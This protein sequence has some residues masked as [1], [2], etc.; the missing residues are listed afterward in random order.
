MEPEA[1][2]Q[3]KKYS[4]PK[5][6]RL[7]WI[8]AGVF[9]AIILIVDLLAIANFSPA[10]P[11]TEESAEQEQPIQ[12]VAA[13]A[14]T[15]STVVDLA[16]QA[17]DDRCRRIGT[18][19]VCYGNNTVEAQLVPG[20]GG[21]FETPGDT[22]GVNE[23]NTLLTAPLN[24]TA[25]EWG[26]AVFK[27]QADLPGTV[28]GQNVTILV[29]GNVSLDNTSGDMQAF[30]FTTGLGRVQCE[31]VPFDGIVVDMPD[32]AGISLQ[33]NDA[34]VSLQGT[35]MLEAEEGESMSINLIKGFGS[36]AAFGR[37]QIVEA[38]QSVSMPLGSGGDGSR[39]AGPP[40]TP[41]LLP[42]DVLTARCLVSGTPCGPPLETASGSDEGEGGV[43]VADVI[44]PGQQSEQGS[45]SSGS[46]SGPGNSSV[47]VDL[48]SSGNS[49]Q[50][51]AGGG[52]SI[53]IGQGQKASPGGQDQGSSS[54]ESSGSGGNTFE[55]ITDLMEQFGSRMLTVMWIIT[56]VSFVVLLFIFLEARGMLDPEQIASRL[57]KSESQGDDN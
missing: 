40:S 39:V 52:G 29:T 43:E 50:S 20:S 26:I 18:S 47:D 5:K 12:Q 8:I 9:G 31:Q 32:G 36:I 44:P 11:S 54:G 1:E 30:Y 37:E 23:L 45:G 49:G 28:P 34:E 53:S 51:G 16:L 13:G 19:E 14:P 33:V 21:Q 3:G 57:S 24:P 46:G 56:G 27:L 38:G 48:G 25:N 7:P 22:V 4:P 41:N 17:S 6:N 35:A 42:Q 15:C 10:G 2:G 55:G